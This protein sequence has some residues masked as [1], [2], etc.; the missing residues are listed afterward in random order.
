VLFHGC[1]LSKIQVV[2]GDCCALHNIP[3][4]GT[5]S[6]SVGECRSGPEPLLNS[7]QATPSGAHEDRVD[8]QPN[9][10]D[11]CAECNDDATLAFRT[12]FDPAEIRALEN[13]TAVLHV[14]GDTNWCA[15]AHG[16]AETWFAGF[17][18]EE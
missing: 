6:L 7:S 2:E 14:A 5:L 11:F 16:Y 4:S 13:V 3:E 10:C 17:S 1:D 12:C 18:S 15:R 9:A 8:R